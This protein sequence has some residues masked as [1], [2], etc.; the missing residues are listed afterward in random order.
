[1]GRTQRLS[2]TRRKTRGRA[3]AVRTIG[4]LGGAAPGDVGRIS[5][6]NLPSP[7]DPW[8][9]SAAGTLRPPTGSV[10]SGLPASC[11]AAMSPRIVYPDAAHLTDQSLDGRQ[12]EVDDRAVMRAVWSHTSVNVFH[13]PTAIKVD[14][15]IAGGTPLDTEQLERRQ[16]SDRGYDRTASSFRGVGEWCRARSHSV[17]RVETHRVTP[18]VPAHA[19]EADPHGERAEPHQ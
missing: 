9:E 6:G 1:M 3:P 2:N 17:V 14:L 19:V 13:R 12:P 4:G 18:A 11:S 10:S 16:H 5:E 15:F 8:P 7:G